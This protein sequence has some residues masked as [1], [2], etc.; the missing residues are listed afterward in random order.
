MLRTAKFV[1]GVILCLSSLSYAVVI[2][3]YVR[4]GTM[5]IIPL[6]GTPVT[7]TNFATVNTDANGFYTCNVPSG[8]SGTVCPYKWGYAMDPVSRSYPSVTTAQTNQNFHGYTRAAIK[9]P[10]RL[11]LYAPDW[12]LTIGLDSINIVA[13]GADTALTNQAGRCTLTVPYNWSGDLHPERVLLDTLND[14]VFVPFNY[15]PDYY[16]IS[17]LIAPLD[18]LTFKAVPQPFLINAHVYRL[19]GRDRIDVPGVEMKFRKDPSGDTILLTNAAGRCTLQVAYGRSFSADSYD[20]RITPYHPDYLF[21]PDYY[22]AFE[23]KAPLNLPE[24]RAYPRPPHTIVASAGSHGSISPADSIVVLHGYDTTF[25]ITPDSGY[26]VNRVTIDGVSYGSITAYR[27]LHVD[28][29]HTIQATFEPITT[30]HTIRTQVWLVG[31]DTTYRSDSSMV[32]SGDVMVNDGN[33]ITFSIRKTNRMDTLNFFYFTKNVYVDGLRDSTVTQDKDSVYY[34]YRM[35]NVRSDHLLMAIFRPMVHHTDYFIA[36]ALPGGSILPSG[37]VTVASHGSLKFRITPNIGYR[38][39]NVT[40]DGISRGAQDS[41][42]FTDITTKS[43]VVAS[44]QELPP[45]V[46]D[47]FRGAA[48]LPRRDVYV[49]NRTPLEMML[50]VPEGLLDITV[51]DCQGTMVEMLAN[52]PCR[53]GQQEVLWQAHVRPGIYFLRIQTATDTR[54]VRVLVLE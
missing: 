36:Y 52:G 48:D 35:A 17:R 46:N 30:L 4:G 13:P 41:L 7:F 39:L 6:P 31:N 2:S 43:V 40:V 16:A 24:F 21:Q 3:G 14:S 28:T 38:I 20:G 9:I 5:V 15:L 42:V 33:A 32:P 44:F 25:T 19:D 34:I 23:V 10:C 12:P 18:S 49:L 45:R 8:W 50:E 54:I 11:S 53:A 51:H 26:T 37:A 22:E 27:F 47:L 1:L 29:A